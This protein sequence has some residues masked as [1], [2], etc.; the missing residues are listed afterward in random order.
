MLKIKEFSPGDKVELQTKEKIWI[1][2]LLES[3][4]QETIL[5]KLESGYNIGIRENSILKAKLI[6]KSL[7][8]ERKEFE[9]QKKYGLKNI[10]LIITGGT[11]SSRLDPKSGGVISTDAQE[12]LNIAPEIKRIA[13]IVKIEKPFMKWSENMHF[14]DWKKLSEICEKHLND[15]KID[16]IIITH[17]TDFL[18]YTASAL[19]FFIKKLNK[20]IA[21]TY[22]QRSIDRAS[23]DASL[24]L[25]CASRYAASDIAEIAVIGHKNSDDEICLA[26]PATK[27]RK[28]HTSK[29]DAF[30]IINDSPIAEITKKKL[31]ILKEF[32]AKDKKR[33]VTLDTKYSD[34]VAIIKI[35]PGQD[36][37]IIN[38]YL[39]KGYKGLILE[40]TGIGQ[41]PSNESKSNFLPKIK[42]A[43]DSGV[44]ICATAQTI[45]GR[46][47]PKVYSAGR[48]LEKTGIIFLKDMTTETAF[49][50]LSW[51]L[52]H[53][54]YNKKEKMLENISG[55]FNERILE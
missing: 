16:G 27:T 32:N 15:E 6:R 5:L 13:N 22:S 38:Y 41:V 31:K 21:L 17:G 36:S 26:M 50:K 11:I 25:I 47:N 45:Y 7:E 43:I 51:V 52:G 20:P 54:N 1:G 30:K 10:V 42:K 2:N 9:I 44:I 8:K 23:T 24:N 55:E 49:V 4:D 34:S 29:R 18:H 19:S 46:L 53:K 48:D 40:V 39:E 3:Y 35:Y 28:M 37:E 12:I 33:K 14:S